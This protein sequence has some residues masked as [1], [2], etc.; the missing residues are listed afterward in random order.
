MLAGQHEDACELKENLDRREHVVL[1][2]L[3]N[4]LSG[5][6]LRDYQH[7]V[8]MKSGLLIEQRELDDKIKLGQEQLKC[9][10]ES[11][12]TDFLLSSRKAA[13]PIQRSV[14]FFTVFPVLLGKLL[15]SLRSID[16]A[17]NHRAD[18]FRKL[19]TERQV[20]YSAIRSKSS[21]GDLVSSRDY[22]IT[23][24]ESAKRKCLQL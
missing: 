5:D 21:W 23:C 14:A 19:N 20:H 13:E 15:T 7:F 12:P 10:L 3:C 17:A 4:Y 8:K 1:D 6:Q 9:L 16:Y 18:Y 24:L 22:N 11:L 2:I